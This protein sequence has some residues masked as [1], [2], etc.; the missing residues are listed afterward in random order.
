[1]ESVS[2]SY[3]HVLACRAC[4]AFQFSSRRGGLT[5]PGAECSR[6]LRAAS[7]ATS[8]GLVGARQTSLDRRTAVS[9]ASA[10]PAATKRWTRRSSVCTRPKQ[11]ITAG[12]GG[13]WKPPSTRRESGWTGSKNRRLLEPIGNMPP[14]QNPRCSPYNSNRSQPSRLDSN[15]DGSGE[16]GAVHS[17]KQCLTAFASST[18]RLNSAFE[19]WSSIAERLWLRSPRTRDRSSLASH[20]ACSSSCD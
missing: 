13:L 6:R 8:Q 14:A 4:L 17:A 12:L 9:A 3:L 5:S 7:T 16:A 1:M 2:R 15:L 18:G 19:S 11:P 20:R 10:S